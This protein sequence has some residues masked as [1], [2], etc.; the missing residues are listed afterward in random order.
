M[1]EKGEVFVEL[2]MMNGVVVEFSSGKEFCPFLR[3]VGRKDLEEGFNLLIDLLSL[4]I[5]LRMISSG[6]TDIIL[7]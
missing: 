7:E 1:R 3:V 2:C 4:S 5:S 6:E